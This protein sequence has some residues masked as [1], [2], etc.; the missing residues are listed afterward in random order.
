MTRA[1]R[2]RA[3]KEARRRAAAEARRSHNPGYQHRLIAAHEQ[4]GNRL[5]GRV[6]QAVIEH[7]RWCSIYKGGA[8]SCVPNISLVPADES[9]EVIVVDGDGAVTTGRKQ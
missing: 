9:G 6:V 4:L 8:C 7:D 1:A 5:R 3:A 2:R